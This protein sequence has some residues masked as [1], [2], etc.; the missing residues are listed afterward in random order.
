MTSS[1]LSNRRVAVLGAGLAGLRAATELARSGLEVRVYEARTRV[2]GRVRGEWCAGHWMDSAWPVLAGCDVALARWAREV[3]LGDLLSPLRPVQTTLLRAGEAIPVDGL[4]LRGAAR[5]PGPPLWERA[6][7]L[8]WGRLLGRYAEKL[9]PS[10]PELAADLDYRSARDHVA[11]YFGRGA[12]EFWLTPEIQGVYGD[13]VDELSRVA[14]LLHAKSLGVGDRRPGL[15]GLPRRPLLE[16]AQTAAEGLEIRRA[17]VVQRIDELPAGG[18]GVEAIDAD[19]PRDPEHFDAVLC[20][21]GPGEASRITSSLLTAAERDFFR[22]VRE[23][24]VV[25]LSIALEGV[26]TGLPQEIRIPRREGSAISSIVIEPGQPGGR[27]PEGRSQLIARARDAFAERWSEMARDVV[28]KN[29]LSS[30]ELALPRMGDRVLTTHLGRSMQPFFA[31]GSYRRLAN[32]QKVQVDRRGAGRRLYWA[33]DY[34][35]GPSFESSTR[36][37]LRAAQAL[38]ADL[39]L[40]ESS[41]HGRPVFI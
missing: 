1:P 17:T 40:E 11:L 9:D 29:M 21:L 35:A 39:A 2:G 37:G 31:V 20:A 8:R 27:A 30:L 10:L 15:P 7:L 24:P 22:D 38:V 4:T 25:N 18:F 12:L 33:G 32:F 41:S 3:E 6:K 19:G 23:R 36:S 14:L 34:L 13:G 16:L 28:A 26:H 5:I